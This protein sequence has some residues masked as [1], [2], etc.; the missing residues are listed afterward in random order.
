VIEELHNAFLT[1]AVVPRVARIR[2]ARPR[3]DELLRARPDLPTES[4]FCASVMGHDVTVRRMLD[5]D[6]AL[7]AA[8][9]GRYHWDPLTYLC[10]PGTCVSIAIV[11]IAWCGPPRYCS[12]P[13]PARLRVAAPLFVRI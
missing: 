4:I 9:E 1:A 7:A 6:P 10:F 13:E 8:T 11:L 2:N 5:Q 3:A 12:T